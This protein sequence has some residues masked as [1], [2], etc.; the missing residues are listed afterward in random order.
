MDTMEREDVRLSMGSKMVMW[1]DLFSNNQRLFLNFSILVDAA[2]IVTYF[3]DLNH[4]LRNENSHF[5]VPIKGI[6]GGNSQIVPVP[7]KKKCEKT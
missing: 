6:Y 4:P 2:K 5:V 7:N 1:G 3:D